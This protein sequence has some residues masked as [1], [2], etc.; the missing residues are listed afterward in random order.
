MRIF[1]PSPYAQFAKMTRFGFC[2]RIVRDSFSFSARIGR[3]TVSHSAHKKGTHKFAN[4]EPDD[5]PM[6][7]M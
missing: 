3:Q 1:L 4:W 5:I 2:V 7:A 6:R